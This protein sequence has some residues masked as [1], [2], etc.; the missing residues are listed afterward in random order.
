MQ[1][2]GNQGTKR[3]TKHDGHKSEGRSHFLALHKVVQ[4]HISYIAAYM[5]SK[6]VAMG[7]FIVYSK[8]TS[9]K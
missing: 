6:E 3:Q 4:T 1:H 8:C 5:S 2:F 9:V 7:A